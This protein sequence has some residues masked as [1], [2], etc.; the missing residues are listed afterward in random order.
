MTQCKK[1]PIYNRMKV[2]YHYLFTIN[3]PLSTLHDQLSTTN[4][5]SCFLNLPIRNI[6]LV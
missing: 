1:Q 5:Q 6:Y 2:Y 4:Y 3:S